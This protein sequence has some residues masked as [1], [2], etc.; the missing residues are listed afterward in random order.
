V[1]ASSKV[2][3]ERGW[4]LH[5]WLFPEEMISFVVLFHEIYGYKRAAVI[6]YFPGNY[7]E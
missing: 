3:C 5:A 6:V 1:L 4:H 7:F 2:A